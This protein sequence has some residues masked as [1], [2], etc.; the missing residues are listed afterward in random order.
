MFAEMQ[1]LRDGAS[2][3]PAAVLA[4]GLPGNVASGELI[5]SAWG[6][7]VANYAQAENAAHQ[8]QGPYVGTWPTGSAYRQLQYRTGHQTLQTS[9]YGDCSWTFPTTF[10]KGVISV[11]VTPIQTDKSIFWWPVLSTMSLSGCSIFAVSTQ[12]SPY[13]TGHPPSMPN[14]WTQVGLVTFDYLAIGV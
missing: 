5:E 7:A 14:V 9:A 10:P 6:N 8:S 1:A 3:N 2:I 12:N 4:N 13:A 11:Q